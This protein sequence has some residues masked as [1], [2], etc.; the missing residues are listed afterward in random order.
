M[1][2]DARQSEQESDAERFEGDGA[3]SRSALAQDRAGL[4]GDRRF[5]S[6]GMLIWLGAYLAFAFT[7]MSLRVNNDGL[8]YY[9]FLQR[10]AGEKT[11]PAYAYQFGSALFD[12]PFYLVAK[13]FRLITG[14]H[15]LLGAPVTEVSIAVAS[16]AA[17][18]V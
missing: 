7:F 3:S 5:L 1:E 14:I 9:N 6:R 17:L 2:E 10:F 12:L 13:L 4:P 11:G 18:I 16:T 15:S 8:V